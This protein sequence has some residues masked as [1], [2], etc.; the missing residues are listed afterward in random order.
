VVD[1]VPCVS[2]RLYI[3]MCSSVMICAVKVSFVFL[4]KSSLL[5]WRQRAQVLKY[6]IGKSS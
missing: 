5:L 4:S 6:W 1:G 3:Y 2:D